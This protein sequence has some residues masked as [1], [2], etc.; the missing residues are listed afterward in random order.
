MRGPTLAATVILFGSL[1]I[2][3][4]NPDL[5]HQVAL[6]GRW[7]E[8][9]HDTRTVLNLLPNGVAELSFSPIGSVR[10]NEVVKVIAGWGVVDGKF[11]LR[12]ANQGNYAG[13]PALKVD[14]YEIAHVTASEFAYNSRWHASVMHRATKATNAVTNPEREPSVPVGEAAPRG[15][16]PRR[17]SGN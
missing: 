8:I 1:Q 9:D 4:S 15:P 5:D 2:A 10:Q 17:V 13:Y 6:V 12:F 16:Y 14:E 7:Y 3:C 11:Q